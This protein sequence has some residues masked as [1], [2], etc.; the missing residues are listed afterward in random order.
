LIEIQGLDVHYQPVFDSATDEIVGAEALARWTHRGEP[1]DPS[2]FIALAE[3]SGFIHELWECVMRKACRFAVDINRG[4]ARLCAVSVNVSPLQLTDVQFDVDV[5]RIL[6]ETSCSPEWVS[7]EVTESV[8]L[9]DMVAAATLRK[10]AAMGLRCSVDDF[11]TGYSNFAHL[12][13]LPLSMLK[14]DKVFVRDIGA[15][16]CTIVSSIIAMAHSLG[17]K[18]VAEGVEY[19][20]ELTALK[21]MGCDFYQGFISSAPIPGDDFKAMLGIERRARLFQSA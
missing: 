18:V 8:G 6:R 10:L 17:L 1:I 13:R 16:E 21:E 15:G 7:F 4:A 11:G 5:L 2:R 12:K 20:E 14:I 9:G 3:S 19:V